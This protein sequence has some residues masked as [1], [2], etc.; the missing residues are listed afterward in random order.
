MVNIGFIG[1]GNMGLPMATNLIKAGYVVTGYDLQPQ[2]IN[3]L[4][5]SGGIAAISIEQAADNQDVVITM[6]QS[7]EQVHKV[8]T[9][10]SGLFAT[11]RPNSLYID[12][13][14]IDVTTARIVHDR[15]ESCGLN[16]VD[17]PVSGGVLGAISA[18]LT[19][20]VGGSKA[21]F[22][23]AD[24]ILK[25]MGKNI[26]HTGESGSGQAAKICNNM[27]LGISMIA[28]SEAFVL[29]EKLGLSNKKLHEVLVNSSGNCWVVDKYVPVPGLLDSVPANNDYQPGFT[30]AMMYK[31][32][33]LSNSAADEIN[34]D[35]AM[36]TK[37]KDI[38]Q[39]FI[40]QGMGNMD[41]S[42][43]IKAI[44]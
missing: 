5:R 7:G 13:S 9:S 25:H 31:D 20:M 22:L 2:A 43:I 23:L 14:T 6:L 19:F 38:Y 27:V 4:E 41:F 29:A 32:L 24:P 35:L 39:K 44:K 11:M 16:V 28:V 37:A 3:A 17:A 33:L 18:S 10:D 34:L 36:V 15:A 8:C 21:S 42:A 1:L 30:A 26:I 12:C 40:E